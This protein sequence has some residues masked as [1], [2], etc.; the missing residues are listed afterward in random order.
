MN[1]IVPVDCDDLEEA[2][3]TMINEAKFWL[4]FTMEN[5]KA[6]NVKFYATWE[7]SCESLD[8]VIIKDAKDYVWPF[9]EKHIAVLVTSTQRY[10]E[11]IV[12]AY[13]FK[14]LYDLNI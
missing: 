11:D 2:K 6:S 5:G 1:I 9:M 13:I 3:I 12:E 8:I 7:E 10:F 14:E 4:F